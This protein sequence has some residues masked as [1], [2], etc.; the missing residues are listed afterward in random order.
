M[1]AATLRKSGRWSQRLTILG[2]KEMTR[3]LM[4][5]YSMMNIIGTCQLG[6]SITALSNT[7]LACDMGTA[8]YFK[9]TPK[10]EVT[11]PSLCQVL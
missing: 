2:M 10:F 8:V 7:I 6:T 5:V 11:V 3:K 1:S 9:V 4:K